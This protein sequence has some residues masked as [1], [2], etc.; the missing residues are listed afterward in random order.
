MARLGAGEVNSKL[1]LT[2]CPLPIPDCRLPIADC[3]LPIA[4]CRLP[5]P[6]SLFPVPHTFGYNSQ[7]EMGLW[8]RWIEQAPPETSGTARET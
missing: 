2:F 8:L 7:V 5:V 1:Y 3:R 6:Y 4:D